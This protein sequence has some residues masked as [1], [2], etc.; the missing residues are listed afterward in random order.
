MVEERSEQA[1]IEY[2]SAVRETRVEWLWYP[3]IPFGKITL[4][5]GDPGDGKS[6]FILH[7][8]S[9]ITTGGLLPDGDKTALCH[10][11]IYQCSE[12]SY[13]DTIKPRLITAA[14][15]IVPAPCSPCMPPILPRFSGTRTTTT[16]STRLPASMRKLPETRCCSGP[17]RRP[18]TPASTSA[19]RSSRTSLRSRA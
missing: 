18:P 16:I 19:G 8:I 7:L 11:V 5:Q 10:S 9:R 1:E 3:Y 14:S 15:R 2:Y 4:L 13:S 12:D 6:T 17:A